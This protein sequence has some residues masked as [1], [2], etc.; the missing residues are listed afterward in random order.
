MGGNVL[1]RVVGDI[2]LVVVVY[3][4]V[5]GAIKTIKGVKEDLGGTKG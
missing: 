3:S 2:L 5:S 1:T 4:L